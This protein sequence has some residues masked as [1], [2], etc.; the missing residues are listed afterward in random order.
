MRDG[1]V[2]GARNA[3]HGQPD[4]IRGSLWIG[5]RRLRD[6]RA[7]GGLFSPVRLLG[8]RGR[9]ILSMATEDPAGIRLGDEV[10][11]LGRRPSIP[12]GP[13]MLGRV[14]DAN[15]KP[16]DGKGRYRSTRIVEIDSAPP[17]ALAER[18]AIREPL[19]CGI[20]AVDAF[21]TC[22]RGQRLGLFGG[23]GVG[24]STLLGM[25]CRGASADVIVMALVGERGREVGGNFWK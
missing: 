6:V 1:Q 11:S 18:V 4:R 12:F 20:R 5:R 13:D 3:R 22:G 14:L 19:G 15:G 25:M 21:T 23:S 24:K 7:A 10:T 17:K 9:T 2:A 16:L 8:F